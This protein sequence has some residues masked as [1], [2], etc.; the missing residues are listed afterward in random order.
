MRVSMKPPLAKV[1]E[2]QAFSTLKEPHY[3]DH[4]VAVTASVRF[5]RILFSAHGVDKTFR[6]VVS[7]LPM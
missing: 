2:A 6:G 7:D 3:L 5:A 1:L 4:R